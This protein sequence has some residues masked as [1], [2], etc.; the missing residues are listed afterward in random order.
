MSKR[1]IHSEGTYAHFVTFS[2]FNRRKLLEPDV[3]K[4]IVIGV[5]ANQL[6]S[7]N[8]I[9]VGFVVMPNHVHALVWFPDERQISL[10][11]NKWKELSSRN[12]SAVYEAQFHSYASMMTDTSTVWQSRYYDF[13]IHSNEKL[14]EKLQYIHNN[15]VRA[16]LANDM[17]DWPWSSARW[18]FRGQSVGIPISWP[19]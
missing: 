15:P 2:C 4:K 17:C 18:Y 3:C 10:T 19:P 6:K 13:N 12:I 9:C 14:H 5:L 8:G 1:R 7:Q 11:M 16:R